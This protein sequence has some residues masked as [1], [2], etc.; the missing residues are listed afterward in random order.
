MR[1]RRRSIAALALAAAALL[2]VPAAAQATL[3]YVKVPLHSVV[4]TAADNGTQ[5]DGFT[6]D[7]L[8]DGAPDNADPDSRSS[9]MCVNEDGEVFVVWL[10]GERIPEVDVEVNGQLSRLPGLGE[11]VEGFDCLLQVGHSLDVGALGIEVEQRGLSQMCS[12]VEGGGEFAEARMLIDA[13][14]D[15]AGAAGVIVEC[16]HE[17]S[18]LAHAVDDMRAEH[19]I[20]RFNLRFRPGGTD[21]HRHDETN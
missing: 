20:G 2:A 11:T 7:I 9:K 5:T 6:T 10:A 14:G 21:G 16:L 15:Q 12:T 1:Y 13:D 4:Y 3:A 17:G 19:D 18:D 8:I